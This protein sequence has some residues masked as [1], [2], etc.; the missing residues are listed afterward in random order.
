MLKIILQKP[1]GF[2][3]SVFISLRLILQH[4][5]KYAVLFMFFAAFVMSIIFFLLHKEV[6]STK[7]SRTIYNFESSI[8]LVSQ[9]HYREPFYFTV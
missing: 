6:N 8:H 4:D 3:I 2:I 7:C 9:Q 1:I 5:K